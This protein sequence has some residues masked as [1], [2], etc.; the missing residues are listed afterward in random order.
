MKKLQGGEIKHFEVK[1]KTNKEGVV[2]FVLKDSKIV[3]TPEELSSFE[4]QLHTFKV[5]GRKKKYDEESSSSSSSDEWS[6]DSDEY[7][8]KKKY[9]YPYPL[10]RD[11]PILYYWYEPKIYRVNTVFVPHFRLPLAPLV[12][13][14]I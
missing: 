5:G 9:I 6:S 13:I 4:E 12:A 2:D 3:S 14:R 8:R 7:Y 10:R 11:Q 1:E